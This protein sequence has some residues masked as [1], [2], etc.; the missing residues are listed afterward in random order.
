[1]LNKVKRLVLHRRLVWPLMTS[2]NTFI[3]NQPLRKVYYDH[4]FNNIILCRT[5]A[6]G[7]DL[8]QRGNLA[9]KAVEAEV[10]FC[11]KKKSTNNQTILIEC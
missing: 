5:N 4:K 7:P 2:V 9:D 10:I 1:M 8:I 3:G 6:V 11:F